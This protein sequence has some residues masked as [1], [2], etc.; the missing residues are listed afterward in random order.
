MCAQWAVLKAVHLWPDHLGWIL[1]PLCR[2]QHQQV[3]VSGGN[4]HFPSLTRFSDSWLYSEMMRVMILMDMYW[5]AKFGNKFL[6]KN[7]DWA[8]WVKTFGARRK[9]TNSA[10]FYLFICLFLF[11]F[12]LF[13]YLITY[14]SIVDLG[15]L[16][17]WVDQITFIDLTS[18]P[19]PTKPLQ[20]N[21]SRSS[22]TLPERA[23]C[24]CEAHVHFVSETY[25][26]VC[27]LNKSLVLWFCRGSLAASR[28]LYHIQWIPKVYMPLLKW[29]DLW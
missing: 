7:K 14:W 10:Q 15:G 18:W 2:C 6:W 21:T 11:C 27:I 4:N 17:V 1:T 5:N 12:F 20:K 19:S 8:W 9:N 29:K 16:T 22:Y 13:F 25:K 28:F 26:A 24:L 23:I 3:K